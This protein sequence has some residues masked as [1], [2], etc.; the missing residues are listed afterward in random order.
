MQRIFAG[1]LS[2]FALS[3]DNAFFVLASEGRPH[4]LESTVNS[5]KE[6]EKK[7]KIGC[8][9]FIM[10]VTK[11]TVEPMLRFITKVTAFEF[12]E[13]DGKKL[14][15]SAFGSEKRVAEVICSVNSSLETS[16]IDMMNSLKIY[17]RG[18]E[19]QALLLKPIF[20]NIVEAHV[21]FFNILLQVYPREV[22]KGYGMLEVD[23]L[24]KFFQGMLL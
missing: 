23:E 15:T 18:T 2:L 17:I 19:T 6:L 5:K 9:A 14:S 13:G 20:S 10:T 12:S 16:F 1:E 7:L 22:L 24:N 3:Q 8:E 4:V 11:S 21:Q